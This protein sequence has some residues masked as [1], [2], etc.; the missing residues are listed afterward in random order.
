MKGAGGGSLGD[1]IAAIRRQRGQEAAKPPALP[2]AFAHL[3]NAF[4]E[5]HQA[6]G[7]SGFGPNPISYAE[8]AAYRAVTGADLSPWEVKVIRALD[9]VYIETASQSG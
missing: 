2:L 6:R 9:T 1:H 4:I 7:S 8:I 5:L 3:W